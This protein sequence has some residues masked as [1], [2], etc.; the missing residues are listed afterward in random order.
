MEEEDEQDQGPHSDT[1]PEEAEEDAQQAPEA[2]AGR[3]RPRDGGVSEERPA[4]RARYESED[5]E[6]LR[7]PS[8]ASSSGGPAPVPG[9]AASGRYSIRILTDVL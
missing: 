7:E 2:V 3:V 6:P 1:E 4:Q 9:G 5:S 8:I